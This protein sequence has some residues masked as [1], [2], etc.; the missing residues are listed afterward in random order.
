VINS[1]AANEIL[2]FRTLRG[3]KALLDSARFHER[4]AWEQ[5]TPF[6]QK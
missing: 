3:G 4:D 2:E 1:R 6:Q 5:P